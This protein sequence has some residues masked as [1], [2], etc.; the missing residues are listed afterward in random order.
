M[1]T[2]DPN[3]PQNGDRVEADLLRNN[4]NALN[5]R[6]GELA[7]QIAAIPAGAPGQDGQDGRDGTDGQPG[8]GIAELRDNGDGRV[9]VVLTNGTEQGP[10]IVASG[11]A[12]RDGTSLV[13]SGDWNNGTGYTAGSVVAYEGQLYV[14][15]DYVMGAPPVMDGRWRLLSITGP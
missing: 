6:A 4:F 5:D 10:F 9:I 15:M 7:G 2:F 13:M 8:V 12:G 1:P 3:H 14:A 11:P